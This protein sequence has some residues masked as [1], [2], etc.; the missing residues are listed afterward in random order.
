MFLKKSLLD[1]ILLVICAFFTKNLVS[2]KSKNIIKDLEN[3]EI[4]KDSNSS[5][6]PQEPKASKEED[7]SFSFS[8]LSE[9]Q[10]YNLFRAKELEQ[11]LDQDFNFPKSLVEIVKGYDQDDHY[12]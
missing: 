2:T 10:E 3:L 12:D 6:L 9:I 4:N 1:R 7:A 11:I 8:P 5:L